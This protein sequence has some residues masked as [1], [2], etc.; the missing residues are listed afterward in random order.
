MRWFAVIGL[1]LLAPRDMAGDVDPCP[2]TLTDVAD[3]AGI[4]FV[5]DRGARGRKRLPETMGAGVA[6]LDYDSDGWLDLYVIQSGPLPSDA[7]AGDPRRANRMFRNLGP[8]P[9]GVPRFE[10]V[11]AGSGE[12][13]YGQGVVAGDVDAD[14]DV[15]LYVAN[16]GRDTLLLN[17]GEGAFEDRTV[18]AGLG[19]EGWSSSAALADYDLDGR[20]DV[21][22][23]RY[24][25]HRLDHDLFC[26]N[27]ETGSRSYCGPELFAGASDRLYRN[28]GSLADGTPTF[29]DVTTTVGIAPDA[30][31]AVGKG[32]GVV[33]TDLDGDGRPDLYVAND[34][35]VNL[36]FRNQDDPKGGVRFE[37]VSFFSGAGV[38][39]QGLPEAGMGIAVGDVDGDGRPELAMTN[40]DVETNTLYTNLGDLQF[41]DAS[42]A[43]GFGLPSFNRLGFGL[44]LV[45]LDRDGALDA[46][47]AN[48]HV[49]EQTRRES[50]TYAEPDLILLGDGR[51]GFTEISCAREGATLRVGR[52]LAQA[53]VDHDGDPDLALSNSGGPLE[54]LL[55]ESRLRPWIGVHLSGPRTPVGAVV[56]VHAGLAQQSRTIVAGDSYQSSGDTRLSF[57]LPDAS[58]EIVVEIA[59]PDGVRRRLRNAPQDGYLILRHP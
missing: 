27:A 33:F 49:R 55:N 29:T 17:N 10:S 21:Y 8:G 44:V 7:P 56:T 15:D 28:T 38:N 50:A 26:G 25:E 57:S 4:R 24:L 1:L 5:H 2:V 43:S 46:Y 53:D 22:V 9:S 45:D 20:L 14:G 59:W 23:T 52:G 51:G 58:P 36:L 35:T 30:T 32:L 41:I 37:D 40:F 18:A 42:V 16:Y 39:E 48:G 31:Q 12:Q 11:A 13:G 54:L 19:L 47:V 6:W 3:E 34:Q